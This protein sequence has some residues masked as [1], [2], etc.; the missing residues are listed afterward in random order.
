[1]LV[2]T[3]AHLF[4]HQFDNDWQAVDQRARE[5][6]L[7]HVLLPNIDSGSV[8]RMHRCQGFDP[9]FYRPMMGIH[10][11]SVHPDSWE[12]EWRMVQQAWLD[13]P[14]R[15]CA[16]G[17]IGLDYYWDTTHAETQREAFR[18]QLELAREVGRPVSIHTRESID[19]CIRLVSEAQNGYLSGVFHCFTGSEAQARQIIDLGFW[20]GIGGVVTFKNSTLKDSLRPLGPH[21]L[22]LETDAPYLAPAPYR[23]KRNESAYVAVI[24]RF[25]AE[26]VFETSLEEIAEV[27]TANAQAVF[28][29]TSASTEANK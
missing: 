19:D 17:E 14:E 27:T 1:M 26:N 8:E 4:A 13:Y 25:L 12:A 28:P 3:H 20:L 2:D 18:R 23:G 10:P 6:G 29:L 5:A 22:V 15:Y 11:T 16:V 7:K 21:K 24:A 9:D